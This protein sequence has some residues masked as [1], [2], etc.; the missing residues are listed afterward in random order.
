MAVLARS[1]DRRGREKTADG[2]ACASSRKDILHVDP[3]KLLLLAAVTRV[4]GGAHIPRWSLVKCY[5]QLI[6]RAHSFPRQNLTNSVAYLVN[7]AAHH[8]NTDEILRLTE[9]IQVE[10][11][12]LIKS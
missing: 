4:A 7:S 1:E 5:T 3:V 11:H 12:G 2:E 9:A 8:G 10:F 6:A